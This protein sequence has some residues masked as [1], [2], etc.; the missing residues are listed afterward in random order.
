MFKRIRSKSGAGSR[1]V[2]LGIL[3]TAVVLVAT[4]AW[5]AC[6]PVLAVGLARAVRTEIA[7]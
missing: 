2:T 5:L 1:L 6:M 7:R 4:P 3:A